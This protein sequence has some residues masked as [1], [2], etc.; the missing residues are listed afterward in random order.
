M[1]FLRISR[2]HTSGK[3][4]G[5]FEAQAHHFSCVRWPNVL[6]EQDHRDFAARERTSIHSTNDFRNQL[7]TDAPFYYTGITG[8]IDIVTSRTVNES[9][10]LKKCVC[11]TQEANH[12]SGFFLFHFLFGLVNNNKVYL[13]TLFFF[14]DVLYFPKYKDD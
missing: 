10:S 6:F 9:G 1:S 3:H 13:S 14:H 7:T 2:S 12:L 8:G 11:Q 5:V 4:W